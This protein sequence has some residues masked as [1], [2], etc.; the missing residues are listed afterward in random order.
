[1][2]E[3]SPRQG[4]AWLLAL[5]FEFRAAVGEREMVHL[6]ETPTL[7]DVPWTP[8]YCR[9]ILIWNNLLLPAMDL[10]A[11]LRGQPSRRDRT[12]AGVFAHQAQPGAE[13][14]Y[15]A[16]LMAAIPER[17]RVTDAQACALLDQPAGW[18]TL[19]ISCFQRGGQPVPILDLPFIFTG[20]LQGCDG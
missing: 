15:G 8:S 17:V 3:S 4:A 5:D 7:L 14:S 9:Q 1:M 2:S 11:W 16:L 19:A 18:R 20:G 13:P 10:A 6:I 12:L